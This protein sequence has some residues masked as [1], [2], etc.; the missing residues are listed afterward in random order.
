VLRWLVKTAHIMSRR[1]LTA[2]IKHAGIYLRTPGSQKTLFRA[3]R[4]YLWEAAYPAGISWHFEVKPRGVYRLLDDAVAAYPTRT[5]LTFQ[6]K[7]YSYRNLADLVGKVAN[8]LRKFGVRRGTRVGLFLPNSPYFVICYYA[9]LKA[10]GTVVNF[11]PL[12]AEREIARQIED[13]E[14]SIMITLDLQSLYSKIAKQ[15]DHTC[16]KKV[17]VCPMNS[18]LRFPLNHFFAWFRRKEVAE[19]PTDERHVMFHMLIRNA[20]D[21]EPP[22]IDPERDVAVLQYTGGISGT[23]KGAM[24]TH[25][26]LYSN[27]LQ[28]KTFATWVK[29][30][31]ETSLVL[32]PLCHAFG[33]TVMNFG[34][35][36]GAEVVLSPQFKVGDIFNTIQRRRCTLL[37]GVPTIYSALSAHRV[38]R[39]YDLSSLRVCISGG[40]PLAPEVKSAFER[41]AGCT[42]IDGYGLTEASPVCSLVPLG[43]RHKPR[44]VGLPLPGTVIEIASLS[45]P[46]R[47]LPY[48]ELGEIC[49]RGPQVMAGYWKQPEETEAVLE[50]R[51]LRTGDFG[52]LDEDGYLFI[53]DRVKEMI[54]SGGFNVYP[55]IV[56]EALKLH[57]AVAHAF[58][59]G[60]PDHHRGERVKAY[61]KPIAGARLTAVELRAFLKSKLAPFEIPSEIEFV[62]EIPAEFL[63]RPTRKDL[64]NQKFGSE[65][66]IPKIVRRLRGFW[67][68]GWCLWP[69][70][71]AAA[72]KLKPLLSEIHDRARA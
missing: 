69:R 64:L 36:I 1:V 14:T 45:H 51:L 32:I 17:I 19:I 20:P 42:I 21:F 55:G 13:S 53:V 40:A 60:L 56:E 2:L 25:A 23:P 62:E 33:M 63:H 57:P 3:A 66:L 15:L 5:C 29:P 7:K 38:I 11:N 4:P 22:D 30:G 44:S 65:A 72:P 16:L 54:I 59:C 43:G 31:N 26:N 18:A 61:V 8:G 27:A 34:F 37:F 67:Q 49:V 24:L 39:K 28:I 10:G 41:L 47:I 35:A 50:E 12:Y 71:G 58:V 6:G 52:Y 70:V 9:I 48:G 68:S 46:N